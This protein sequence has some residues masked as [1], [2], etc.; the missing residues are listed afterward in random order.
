VKAGKARGRGDK[1]GSSSQLRIP[2]GKLSGGIIGE[3]RCRRRKQPL[4]Q[5]RSTLAISQK[6]D[7]QVAQLSRFAGLQL[8]SRLR[9]EIFAVRGLQCWDRE[10]RMVAQ[11]VGIAKRAGQDQRF[12]PPVVPRTEGLQLVAG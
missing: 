2:I 1:T 7:L 4:P 5:R 8:G 3:R 6:F 9:F 10:P 12:D 11:I